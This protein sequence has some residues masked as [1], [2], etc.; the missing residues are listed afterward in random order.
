MLLSYN[1]S[2][3]VNFPTRVPNNYSSAIDDVFID[4]SK[5]KNY[6]E[7]RLIN[8]LYHYEAQLVEIN[9]TGL[10]SHSQQY[11]T[12][13]KIDKY[14]MAQFVTK[15]SYEAVFDSKFNCFLNTYFRIFYLNFSL[16]GSKMVLKI[17]PGLQQ[18]EKLHIKYKKTNDLRLESHYKVYCKILSIV[19]K[20][21][22]QNN[23]NNQ[24]LESNNKIKNLWEIVKLDS[25]Q[26][27]ISEET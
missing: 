18:E 19:I 7:E 2:S 13:R 10:Q 14:M 15:L 24:I 11:Q 1:L 4:K 20:K 5:L 9:D 25:G 22:K 3:T 27:N 21:A 12:L 17:K 8:G 6:K 23:Y 16:I 26:K